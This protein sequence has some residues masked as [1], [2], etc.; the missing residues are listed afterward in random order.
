MNKKEGSHK[1]IHQGKL[2]IMKDEDK[3]KW[4]IR[5][6]TVK[7]MSERIKRQQSNS[8]IANPQYCETEI[9]ISSIVI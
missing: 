3:R 5:K 4:I 6:D 9:T 2:N 8:N 7:E 1:T